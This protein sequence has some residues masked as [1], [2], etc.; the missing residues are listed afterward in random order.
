MTD[1]NRTDSGN[2]DAI[3]SSDGVVIAANRNI[4]APSTFGVTLASGTTYFFPFGSWKASVPAESATVS[5]HFRWDSAIIVTLTLETCNFPTT[6]QPADSRGPVDVSDF[7]TTAGNWMQE[8]PTSGVYVSGSGS[9]GLTATNL[10]LVVAGG[11][12]GGSTINLGNFGMRRGR[13]R[14]VVGGTGGLMRCAI[15]GKAAA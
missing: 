9:G 6:W 4:G 13:W 12:A 1:L 14:A 7:D 10:T 11:T 2:L 8:N 15:W 3:R 5:T